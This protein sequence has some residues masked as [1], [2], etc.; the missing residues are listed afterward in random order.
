MFTIMTWN[1]ENFF[2]PE[3]ADRADFD[4]KLDALTHVIMTAQPDLL[5]VQEVGDEVAFA[6]LR[7][8][9]GAGWNGELS[10][11]FESSHAIRVGWL[12]PGELSDVQEIT[13]LPE[14]L[15]R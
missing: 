6:A 10:T 9:L 13:D 7:D 4:A 15:S 2:Q 14:A 3:P 8:R 11:H 5:A 12:S 1:I